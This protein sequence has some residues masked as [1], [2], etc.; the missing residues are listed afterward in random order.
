MLYENEVKPNFTKMHGCGNTFAVLLDMD[1]TFGYADYEYPLIA[2]AVSDSRYGLSTDGLLVVNKGDKTDYRM[3]IF[4]KDGSEA[5]MCGNGVR[6]FSRY[7]YD[8]GYVND[9][10][11]P[12]ETY[13]GSIVVHPKLNFKNGEVNSVAVDLGKGEIK[14]EKEIKILTETFLGTRVSVGNPHYVIFSERANE[15]MCETWGPKL[16]KHEEFQ[17]DKTNVEFA[18]ILDKDEIKLHVWERGAG[19]TLGC[20]TGAVATV[21]TAYKKGLVGNEVKVKLPGGTLGIY[22]D[23]EDNISLEGPADYCLDA[24]VYLDKIL[25]EVSR[26]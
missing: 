26:I 10:E 20:G 5:E 11:F 13:D 14:E 17:P 6:C 4:N 9:T 15:T 19:L 22:I 21:L 23:E 12:L 8:R 2:R 18:K 25:K 3:R 1:N 24:E 7:L 16:E